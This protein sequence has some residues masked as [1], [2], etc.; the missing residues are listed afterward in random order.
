MTLDLSRRSFLHGAAAAS[1][2]NSALARAVATA[3]SR[4]TG[5]LMD[6]EHV[7]LFMQENRSFDHYYGTMAGVRG[8]ADPHPYILPNGDPVWRQPDGKGGHVSPFAVDMERTNF[9]VLKSL[10]HH[11]E[12]GHAAYNEGRYDRWVPAKGGLTMGHITRS[13]IPYHFALA[14]AFTVCDSYFCSLKGPT[15]PNRLYYMT[16]S[17]DHLNA[18]LHGPVTNNIDITQ[19]PDGVIFG[20]G[21]RTY[22][23]ALQD[24]GVSWQLYRQGDDD[25]DDN[26]DGGMDTLLA[27]QPFRDAMPGEPLYERGVRPRRLEQLKRDVETGT[28]AQVSWIVPP[29]LFCEHPNWP[30]AYGVEYLARIMDALTANPAVWSK[31]AFIV[32]YDENDG[33]FDHIVPPTPA[34]SRALGLSSVPVDDERHPVTGEAYGLGMRVP[35][36]VISP[37]SKGGWVCSETFDHTSIL[38]FLE[39]RFGVR[40]DNVTEWRRTVCGDLTS[41]FDFAHPKAQPPKALASIKVEKALPDKA[42]FSAYKAEVNKRPRPTVPLDPPAIAVEAGQRP[43]RPLA[44]RLRVESELKGDTL[45][46]SFIN[47][48][49]IGAHFHVAD[50]TKA[51]AIPR[52]YTAAAGASLTDAWPLDAGRYEL[53]VH[54]PAGHVW[55][56]TGNGKDQLACRIEPADHG[57]LAVILSNSEPQDR[58]VEMLDGQTGE[59]IRLTLQP[60]S[61]QRR[62]LTLGRSGGWYDV[63][64]KSGDWL[65][66]YAGRVETGKPS[67]TDPAI[68]RTAASMR[69]RKA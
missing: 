30:P 52:R 51:D 4:V 29:R 6:V 53:I 43:S 19:K 11:W 58:D 40:A 21:W 8:Y 42:T 57:N 10:D 44:Y 26:S 66:R 38:R 49:A 28:L 24:A 7:V 47:D 23:E 67:V 61:S 60:G 35:M 46:L 65:R 13:D 59:T 14:D 45:A 9:P 5:T 37:W 50:R 3:P 48:G 18:G 25:S 1:L 31:T 2:F 32:M 56:A 15:C 55:W 36:L 34:L 64:V 33:Y 69:A 12:S 20:A 63:T 17:V 68:A 39:K 16:G 27:F 62:T 41:A 54:G 22:A